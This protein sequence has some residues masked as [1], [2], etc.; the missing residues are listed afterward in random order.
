MP[1][2]L[3]DDT[4]SHH[5]SPDM[6]RGAR[7]AAVEAAPPRGLQRQQ[8]F[9]L[10]LIALVNIVLWLIPSD[11][12]K[13]IANERQVMLGRYSRVHF[14]WIVGVA[15]ISLVGVYINFGVGAEHRRRWFR[16]IA[17]L[18]VMVPL[19]IVAD[20]LMRR[21]AQAHYVRDTLAYHRPANF[22]IEQDFSDKPATYRTY[23]HAPKGYG[24][25]DCK[26]TTDANGYR[27]AHTLAQYDIVALGDSFTEG[28]GVS[29]EQPW[30]V[31]LHAHTGL[32]V[33]NLGMSGYDPFHYLESFKEHGLALRPRYVVCMIYEGNDF[34]SAKSDRKRRAPS[35]SAKFK[36]YMKQS[37][38]IGALDRLLID[39]FGPINANGP[40]RHAEAIDWMPLMIPATGAASHAYAFAPKQLRDLYLPEDVFAH[41]KHWLNPRGQ[42]NR[43]HELCEQSGAKLVVVFAPTKAHVALPIVADKLNAEAVRTFTKYKYKGELPEADAFLKQLVS[44]VESRENVMRRWC[45]RESIPF[46][47]VTDALRQAMLDGRQAYYTYDQHWTP[48]GHEVAATE[49]A[50]ELNQIEPTS[51][52][53]RKN[54]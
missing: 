46:V 6:S 24:T 41:D 9:W 26:L 36:R 2:V 8:K 39:T 40:V 11:V 33:Y 18:M 45:E 15:I 30:P 31:R 37:P 16:V 12:A 35:R 22:S 32:S 43:I 7:D 27:N 52:R 3:S 54:N 28:S 44:H 25:V 23:P 1:D 14:S 17:S 10:A 4:Q 5:D 53:V 49:I 47:S 50:R 38:V 42:I 21:P 19:L 48:I 13:Q 51:A 29:D 34:R 20:F